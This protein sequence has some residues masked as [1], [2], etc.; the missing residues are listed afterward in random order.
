MECIASV[1]LLSL[2]VPFVG[3]FFHGD[4]IGPVAG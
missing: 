2:G 3:E 1:E 4:P